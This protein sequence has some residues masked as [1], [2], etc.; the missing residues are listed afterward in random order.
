LI[1]IRPPFGV[2]WFVIRSTQP[3]GL[4]PLAIEAL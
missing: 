4:K 3:V 1:W 2:S